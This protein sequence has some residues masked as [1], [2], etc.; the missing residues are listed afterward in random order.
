MRLWA[1][2]WPWA[3]KTDRWARARH[4]LWALVFLSLT[5]CQ[6][7]PLPSPPKRQP[8]SPASS[9]PASPPQSAVPEKAVPEKA[10]TPPPP[11]APAYALL[12]PV[13]WST[14][15]GLAQEDWLAS[16]RPWLQSCQGLMQKPDWQAVCQAAQQVK[17][18]D[19]QAI[20]AYWQ[21]RFT[22]YAT[23]QA[24]GAAQGL[25]TGYYQPVLKGARTPGPRASVP[26]Y[27][28]PPDLITVNLSGLF[29]ELKYKR[30]RGRLQGQT[31]V[32]YY[33][34]AEI[35][36]PRT[37]LAGHEL[38]WVSDAVEAFFLQVQGSGII[39]LESGERLPVGYADQ[40]GHPYQSIGKLL[41]ERGA[42][43]VSEAS[44]QGI[45][46]WGQQHPEQLRA[47]LDANPSYVFFKALPPG[48]SGPL[49]ALGVPLTASR[50]IAVDPFYI[51]LGAPVF[52]ATTYPN[53]DKPLQQLMHAQDTGGAI[54]GGVRADVYWGE[55]E[56]AGKLA[57]AMRQTGQLW[58]WLPNDFPLPR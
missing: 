28:T 8:T 58:V 30:V 19:A 18:D 49:G 6:T 51:P 42:L 36:Q 9:V 50:S 46:Q 16:W 54:K 32:P 20:Q 25:I 45:K 15:P 56:P 31:L 23:Q 11:G 13:A 26:L 44:M 21:Q 48:L 17:A 2:C 3:K 34:R 33:T 12:K 35:E 40:N 5:A 53:S 29:P 37:P 55:G 24:D 4:G 27:K 57:G 52:L 43:T 38:V 22:V 14:L 41:V 7:V 47:L 1:V 10:V 39:E